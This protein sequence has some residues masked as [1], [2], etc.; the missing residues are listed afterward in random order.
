MDHRPRTVGRYVIREEIARGGMGVVYRA[1]APDGRPVALKLLLAGR[2]ATPVQRRR[3]STEVHTLLRI[4]HESVVTLLDAGET[5]EGVPWL[6]M[7]WVDGETLEA[8]LGREGPLD[9]RVAVELVR[10]L[11][12]GVSH[13]HEQGV[14]HRDLKPA[15]VLLRARDGAPLL[16]DFGLSKDLSGQSLSL[17]HTDPGVWL[18][19]PGFWPPEQSRGET[20][21][22]GPRSDVYGLGAL[23]YAALTGR[24]PQEGETLREVLI[25]LERPP[26]A[27]S[28]RRPG[29]PGWLDAS[30]LR[31]LSLAPEDRQTSAAELGAEL[32]RGLGS[33]GAR[34]RAGWLPW[35]AAATCVALG[36]ALALWLVLGRSA[37]PGP[38]AGLALLQEARACADA[39]RYEEAIAACDRA[40]ALDSQRAVAWALRGEA[41]AGAGRLL[42]ALMDYDRA[43]ALD[44]TQPAIFHLR[45][46][47]RLLQGETEG[48]LADLDKALELAPRDAAALGTRGAALYNQGRSEAALRDLDQAVALEPDVVSHR[49]T[50]G[51][52]RLEL[53]RARDAIED[54][55]RV[56]AADPRS[57][58]ALRGR[59]L[60]L[61]RLGEHERAL[62]DYQRAIEVDP[63]AALS[64]FNRGV[65]LME[66][67][68]DAEA[69]ESYTR[70]IELQPRHPEAC[71]NRGMLHHKA[72]RAEEALA[73]FER[74][75]Q[76][77]PGLAQAWFG[78]GVL[79]A[80]QRRYQQALED[81]SRAVDLMPDNP[82]PW[83]ERG[84]VRAILRRQGEARADFDR[85]EALDP[86]GE[87]GEKARTWRARLGS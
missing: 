23:L 3:V 9:W 84:R 58:K 15:N 50:R 80:S 48:A 11:A 10:R 42:D 26:V 62:A 14:L 52:V 51:L 72:G 73:D 68:R 66:L 71:T 36:L 86:R 34:R 70:A 54:F 18:G 69:V 64:W 47:A 29:I 81:L 4:R 74:A 13:C 79:H 28:R 43:I 33:P 76:D 59:G 8:R 35:A 61:A 85:A 45:G 7:E 63:A 24:R 38:A 5:A 12:A 22:I 2:D 27:P 20:A 75:L 77:E 19:T 31:A 83:L 65:S 6:A 17:G 55:E 39:G 16:T 44:Q 60:A 41:H 32:A 37:A 87:A 1:E 49:D 78:R 56:L 82:W 67:G 57:T 21:R 30:C 25:A 53:G 40:L 46:A